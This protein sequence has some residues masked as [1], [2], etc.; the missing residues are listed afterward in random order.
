MPNRQQHLPE[1]DLLGCERY[2]VRLVPYQPAWAELFQQ[3][4]GQLRAALGDRVVRIE[5]VGSTSIPG[6]DAKPIL[7][8][9]V[10][11][12]DMSDAG[13]FE[14]ALK[15]LG[16]M[17]KA[18]NDMPG[19]LYFP[20]RLPDDR[21]THHLNITELNTECWFTHVA[22][23]D[24]LRE[25]P[26]AREEYRNLKLDLV[27][28]HSSDRAAYQ[29]GKAAF[30][31]RILSRGEK[32]MRKSEREPCLYHRAPAGWEPSHP[33]PLTPDGTYGRGWGSF[34]VLD[35]DDDTFATGGGTD[36]PSGA[37][38]GKRVPDLARRLCDFIR[39]ER[40]HGR[41]VIVAA[42]EG[43]DIDAMIGSAWEATAD[44]RA[45]RAD[46]PTVVVHSTS[47]DAWPRI[48][49]DGI[50][51][52]AT[53][54]LE[55]GYVPAASPDDLSAVSQYQQYEPEEYADHIMFGHVGN[56]VVECVMAS[57]QCGDFRLD[58]DAGYT[59]GVRLYFDLH[60]II[61][62]GLG[63]RDGLHLVKVRNHLPLTPYLLG[64]VGVED[65]AAGEPG[66]HWTPRL[67]TQQ[68][69]SVFEQRCKSADD[70]GDET[71][72]EDSSSKP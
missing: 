66:E 33:N 23:R 29:E 36:A 47:Q 1:S 51:K 60:T 35:R 12:R 52:S 39:Y 58:P 6:L 3:E 27:S 4:A 45:I 61:R 41:Q 32:G 14:E 15:P 62:D 38:A 2:L 19:R 5:H 13:T 44:K 46:D 48:Q 56:P 40:S 37:Q 43:F 59:P 69:D 16:Y 28:R 34:C 8:I 70:C 57:K 31:E 24:Y 54:L 64:V 53:R 72:R 18:E 49:R 21:S 10:A 55:E 20:K 11:V 71:D 17:H 7:D 68:A 25:H 67:F 50:L 63:V 26:E 30:I 65:V 42:P 9:V 22:F